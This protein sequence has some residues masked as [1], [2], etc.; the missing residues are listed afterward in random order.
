MLM[1][2]ITTVLKPNAEKVIFTEGAF[3]YSLL[4]K[5]EVIELAGFM[6][7]PWEVIGNI[8]SNLAP[9]KEI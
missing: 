2:K 4:G 6:S 7:E 3:Q 1:K 9:Y 8:Y 5:H